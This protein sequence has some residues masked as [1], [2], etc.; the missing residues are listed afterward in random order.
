MKSTRANNLPEWQPTRSN[1][2]CLSGP[3]KAHSYP[4][5][6]K[7]IN[8]YR[9]R[10]RKPTKPASTSYSSHYPKP[11]ASCGGGGGSSQAMASSSTPAA[12]REMQKDLEVQANALSKIQKGTRSP[13]S[14]T[15]PP[16]RRPRTLSTSL[17][18]S[19]DFRRS[20]LFSQT[21]PRTTRSASSTP[22]RSARTS[23]SSRHAPHPAQLPR[24]LITLKVLVISSP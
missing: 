19:S 3:V 24:L 9:H 5:P 14:Q 8:G 10:R 12:V 22:S 13:Q 18:L 15:P 7:E 11:A 21:S 2:T 1:L 4:G 16:R 23:S 17:S 20:F 6:R